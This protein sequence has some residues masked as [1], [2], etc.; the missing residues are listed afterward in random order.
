M[1]L[2]GLGEGIGAE[3]LLD[4]SA[5]R[6]CG[7]SPDGDTDSGSLQGAGEDQEGQGNLKEFP[8]P[9]VIGLIVR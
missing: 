9:G 7:R 6:H 8:S 3:R 1:P 4:P 2:T 5:R